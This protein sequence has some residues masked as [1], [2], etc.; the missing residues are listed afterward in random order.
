[1]EIPRILPEFVVIYVI[2]FS[3]TYFKIIIMKLDLQKKVQ[4]FLRQS[5]VDKLTNLLFLDLRYYKWNH[6]NPVNNC[7][8]INIFMKY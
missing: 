3:K 5:I 7:K 2:I 6:V 4:P 1:M 8:Y